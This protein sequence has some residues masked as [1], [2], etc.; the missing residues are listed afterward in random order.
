MP[1]PSS[2]PVF[3]IIG[4]AALFQHFFDGIS[5]QKS[6]VAFTEIRRQIFTGITDISKY[7]N[8]NPIKT[9]RK[10]MRFACIMSFGKR[11]DTEAADINRFIRVKGADFMSFQI[12]ASLLMC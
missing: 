7:P 3:K 4:I 5:F 8:S 11:G 2:Y 9:Y 6:G 12:E 10:T 1:Q